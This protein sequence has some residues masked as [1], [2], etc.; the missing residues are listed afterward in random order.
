MFTPPPIPSWDGLHPLV[1]HFPIALFFV[2]PV[3]VAAAIFLPRKLSTGFALSALVMMVLATVFAFVA[4]STGEAAGELAERWQPGVEAAIERHEEMAETART[5]F[6]VLT[7]IFAVLAIGPMLFNKKPIPRPVLGVV[8]GVFL[9]L[10]A[11][12]MVLLANAAHEGGVLVHEY[13][14]HALLPAS[15]TGPATSPDY[16]VSPGSDHDDDD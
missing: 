16:S 14:V 3:L 6:A 1:I 2:A 8:Y 5:V 12:A 10:Y 7:G 4:V 15:N 13:G 9:F 11:P